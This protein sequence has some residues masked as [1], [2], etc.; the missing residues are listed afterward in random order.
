MPDVGAVQRRNCTLR[1]GDVISHVA[2]ALAGCPEVHAPCGASGV[3]P[4][5]DKP[6]PVKEHEQVS[7]VPVNSVNHSEDDLHH[8]SHLHQQVLQDVSM[9]PCLY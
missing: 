3:L 2:V 6:I 9:V 5:I 8:Q 4:E 7:V 1:G